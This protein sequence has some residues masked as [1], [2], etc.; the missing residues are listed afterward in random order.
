MHFNIT[1]NLTLSNRKLT[2]QRRE[3]KLT[4]VTYVIL[5]IDI[6]VVIQAVKHAPSEARNW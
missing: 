1:N 2:Q 4:Y 6:K 3:V 5:T